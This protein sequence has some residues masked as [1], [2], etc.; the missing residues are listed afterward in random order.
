MHTIESAIALIRQIEPVLAANG[1]HCALTGSV[2]FKGS[3][4]KDVDVILYPH[5]DLAVD[6]RS[7]AQLLALLAPFGLAC[8]KDYTEP[9]YPRPVAICTH[10]TGRV[11]LFVF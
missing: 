4:E 6:Q 7:P 1:Y 10:P 11:D 2:L 3:S 8:E 9:Q 5:S